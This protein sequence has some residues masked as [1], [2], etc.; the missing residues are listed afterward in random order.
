MTHRY[1]IFGS[2][3]A[4]C[5]LTLSTGAI[6]QAQYKFEILSDK[7]AG[8]VG[9]GYPTPIA[10]NH[11]GVVVGY[12]QGVKAP[13][14]ATKW[15]KK[16]PTELVP[17]QKNNLDASNE[18]VPRM[19]SVSSVADAIN[20][21]GVAVGW[22]QVGPHGNLYDAVEWIDDDDPIVLK[23]PDQHSR[24]QAVGIS[25]AGVVF[26]DSSIDG[27]VEWTS[28]DVVVPLALP[29][30]T[31][32]AIAWGASASGDVAGFAYQEPGPDTVAR[33]SGVP[34]FPRSWTAMETTSA[35]PTR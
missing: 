27:A 30:G 4:I 28:P 5:I 22:A 20:A 29:E 21:D 34:G 31:A 32:A 24:C 18:L 17:P 26:G 15:V 8:P 3:F 23:C 6:A 2:V 16:K 10:I 11:Q 25:D 13:V 1:S 14:V 7:H 12:S 35:T 19:V 33:S 9:G